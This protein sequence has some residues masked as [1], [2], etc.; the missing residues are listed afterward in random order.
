MSLISDGCLKLEIEKNQKKFKTWFD[1]SKS[2]GI[3]KTVSLISA[4]CLKLEIEKKSK[5]VQNLIWQIK[6]LWYIKKPSQLV[7]QV[8]WKLNSAM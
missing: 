7:M 6:N 3:L 5:K 8:V 4:G 2:Y 1:K